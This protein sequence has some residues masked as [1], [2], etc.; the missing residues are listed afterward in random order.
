MFK[1]IFGQVNEGDK[2]KKT[3]D[4]FLG[5]LIMLMR[6]MKSFDLF[7]IE[8]KRA[9]K[10]YKQKKHSWKNVFL[11]PEMY[12]FFPIFFHLPKLGL[13][14]FSEIGKNSMH[15]LGRKKAHVFFL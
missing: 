8:L 13:S 2:I 1:P 14:V 11:S 4:K 5:K 15:A 12:L 10:K 7:Q 3:F 9:T 6:V